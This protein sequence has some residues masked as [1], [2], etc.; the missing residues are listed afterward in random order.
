MTN[1]TFDPS[2]IDGMFT[3]PVVLT[4]YELVLGLLHVESV[5]AVRVCAW[6]GELTRHMG[7]DAARKW[8]ADL[9]DGPHGLAMRPVWE[10]LVKLA[11][12]VDEINIETMM[13]RASRAAM[14]ARKF[15]AMPK[16]GEL[17]VEGRA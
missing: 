15:D 7:Q 8:A 9:R 14:R 13:R 3:D 16:L 1:T 2:A 11:A 12:R 6:D 4:D 5:D 10:A 17:V